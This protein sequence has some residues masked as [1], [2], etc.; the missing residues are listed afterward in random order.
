MVFGRIRK[1]KQNGEYYEWVNA[2]DVCL[3]DRFIPLFIRGKER[4]SISCCGA[5]TK[6]GRHYDFSVMII[7]S[8]VMMEEA[9]DNRV[10]GIVSGLVF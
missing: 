10:R 4:H 6:Q 3:Y 2:I 5:Q 1:R 8:M 9:L 7:L